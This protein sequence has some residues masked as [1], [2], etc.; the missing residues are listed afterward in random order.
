M[1]FQITCPSCG[2]SL[3]AKEEHAGRKVGCPYCKSPVSIKAPETEPAAANEFQN[4]QTSVKKTTSTTPRKKQNQEFVDGTNVNL[5]LSG[6]LGLGASV[7]F[8]LLVA[9]FY[10]TY[11]GKLFI[12]PGDTAFWVPIA[13][14]FMMCWSGVILVLKVRKLK[15]QRA[16]ML[17]DLLPNDISE[18]ITLNNFPQFIKHVNDLPIDPR[19]SFLINRVRRGLEH[20]WVRKSAPE[21]GTILSSQSEIDA[22]SV[23]SSYTILN[24]FIWAIPIMGFIGTV[25]GISA[26]VGG[27]SGSLDATEDISKLKDSLNGVTG[28]LATAFDTTLVALVMSMLVMF[29][30]SS[31]QKAE[32]DLLNWVDEY[33]NE[34]L[35]KRLNDGRE[36]G[37]ER[38]SGGDTTAMKLAIHQAMSKHHAE[39]ETWTKKLE[40]IGSTLTQQVA[41]G[42]KEVQDQ[43][44]QVLIQKVEELKDLAKASTELQEAALS[45]GTYCG[46]L[47]RG[48]E[49]LN[50]TLEDL[51]AKDMVISKRKRGW[52]SGKKR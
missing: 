22:N 40:S 36:G 5:M 8:F 45:L 52:F 29:P 13:L 15:K 44:N 50:E 49:K 17:F 7:V 14:V 12:K 25:I 33:C 11:F 6:L 27:F 23:D 47:G 37:A 2:K 38:G 3:R 43:E 24:V 48:L 4:I 20:F 34:N 31:I 39:L 41:G 46:D 35:L 10:G 42:L 16:S 32:E 26:A 51:G 30:S 18:E 1:Y 28:G 19:E 21:V 9:P